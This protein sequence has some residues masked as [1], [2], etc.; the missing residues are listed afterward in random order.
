MSIGP[1]ERKFG[2]DSLTLGTKVPKTTFT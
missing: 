2:V 1:E